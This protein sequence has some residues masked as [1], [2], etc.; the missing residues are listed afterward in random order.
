M[1]IGGY[2]STSSVFAVRM[3]S[4]CDGCY[5]GHSSRLTI[6]QDINSNFLNVTVSGSFKILTSRLLSEKRPPFVWYNYIVA[7]HQNKNTLSLWLRKLRE[8]PF[9]EI[10]LGRGRGRCAQLLFKFLIQDFFYDNITYLNLLFS[11]RW[12]YLSTHKWKNNFLNYSR[13]MIFCPIFTK[14]VRISPT[15]P[16]SLFWWHFSKEKIV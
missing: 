1:V 5:H 15:P 9:S 2:A 11:L 7:F 4:I 14:T 13:C 12:K 16:S 10:R 8:G 3:F 6:I